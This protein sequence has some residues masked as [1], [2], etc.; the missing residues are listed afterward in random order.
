MGSIDVP[1]TIAYFQKTFVLPAYPVSAMPRPVP[2]IQMIGKPP[3]PPTIGSSIITVKP[4]AVPVLP[5]NSLFLVKAPGSHI[6]TPK[7]GLFYT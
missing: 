5:R 6:L 2:A 1:T 3:L 7:P 4:T